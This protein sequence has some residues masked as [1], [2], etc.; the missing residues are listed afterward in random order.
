[1]ANTTRTKRSTQLPLLKDAAIALSEKIGVQKKIS[2]HDL[3]EV[4][5]GSLYYWISPWPLITQFDVW[6]NTSDNP[7][8][9]LNMHWSP[10]G[11]IGVL[12]FRR[13]DWEQVILDRARQEL[14]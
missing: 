2:G 14:H 8:K 13:G 9:V 10:D 4:D 12:S 6:M 5:L 7:R 11:T 1:M 3:I